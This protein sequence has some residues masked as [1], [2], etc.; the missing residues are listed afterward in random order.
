MY[1]GRIVETGTADEVYGSSAHPYTQALLSA[2]PI[3]DPL[4]ERG[5]RRIVLQG[6]PPTPTDPPSGCRFRTR[7][8]KATDVC[9]EETPPLA[10]PGV[11]HAVA[12]HHPEPVDVVPRPTRSPRATPE[13]T[14]P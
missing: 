8:W 9:A 11:G 10:D 4:V 12:C 1:L 3:P 2:A 5:R 13:E 7:C 14:A 6:E